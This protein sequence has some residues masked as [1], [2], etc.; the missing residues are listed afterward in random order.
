[1][2]S[3]T[4]CSPPLDVLTILA[5]GARSGARVRDELESEYERDVPKSS[6]YHWLDGLRE[7]GYVEKSAQNGRAKMYKATESGVVAAR[8]Y[9]GANY[10]RISQVPEPY[11]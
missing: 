10:I 3:D 2:P 7:R 4:I 11:R 9:I 6:V 1:M 8:E 5:D